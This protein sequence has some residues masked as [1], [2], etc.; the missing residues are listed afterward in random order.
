MGDVVMFRR[1]VPVRRRSA[2]ECV[3]DFWCNVFVLV[4]VVGAVLLGLRIIR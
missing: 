4:L 2:G 3:M 1:P